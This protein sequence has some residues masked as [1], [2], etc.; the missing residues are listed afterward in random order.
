MLLNPLHTFQQPHRKRAVIGAAFMGW[1]SD[2]NWGLDMNSALRRR[3][4]I[5]KFISLRLLQELLV[6]VLG[7]KNPGR[8]RPS[9]PEW[10]YY[11]PA[12]PSGRTKRKN[13]LS[14]LFV[15]LV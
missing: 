10:Q 15:R 9:E 14:F 13:M 4:T 8:Y 1:F 11:L 7:R 12:S 6:K 2:Y 3:R 5:F